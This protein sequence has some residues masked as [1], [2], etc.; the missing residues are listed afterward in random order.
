MRS[1]RTHILPINNSDEVQTYQLN[2]SGQLNLLNQN[3]TFMHPQSPDEQIVT[4]N[5][6]SDLFRPQS[7]R[8]NSIRSESINHAPSWVALYNQNNN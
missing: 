2:Q 3:T 8:P 4:I 6:Q 5:R 1:A 7:R